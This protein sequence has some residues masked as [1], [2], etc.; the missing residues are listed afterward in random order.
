ME[1]V[2]KGLQWGFENECILKTEDRD[3]AAALKKKLLKRTKGN[4]VFGYDG[5]INAGCRSDND[6][7]YEIR[8][9]KLPSER[10]I[11]IQKEVL[12]FISQ[13][14]YTNSS[15]GLH[16]NVSF[17]D[18]KKKKN[19]NPQTFCVNP[20]W[21]KL[22][23]DFRRTRNDYCEYPLRGYE[24]WSEFLNSYENG[25][26]SDKSSCINLDNYAYFNG[27]TSRIEIRGFGNSDYEKKFPLIFKYLQQIAFLMHKS[28]S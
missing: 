18:Q 15:C 11:E 9:K 2:F 1:N 25:R 4:V 3:E 22:L 14:G 21:V 23:K 13:H 16:A 26:F 8:T 7:A 27:A 17:I 12:D 10:A 6:I 24:G 19:F 28:H 5:S 20:L